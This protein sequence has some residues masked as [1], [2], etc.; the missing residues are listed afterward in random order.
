LLESYEVNSSAANR[1]NC[2]RSMAI[3]YNSIQV[4]GVEIHLTELAHTGLSSGLPGAVPNNSPCVMNRG[5]SQRVNIRIYGFCEIGI[6]GVPLNAAGTELVLPNPAPGPWRSQLLTLGVAPSI[7][8]GIPDRRMGGLCITKGFTESGVNE[9]GV[10]SAVQGYGRG[11][12]LAVA[13]NVMGDAADVLGVAGLP[14]TGILA[15]K[16]ISR[17]ISVTIHGQEK[18]H[19]NMELSIPP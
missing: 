14:G 5:W 17:T 15:G 3:G 6:N 1:R 18:D 16:P 19:N 9:F 2:P 10:G 7:A 12:Y 4:N 11:L 13:V 8:A